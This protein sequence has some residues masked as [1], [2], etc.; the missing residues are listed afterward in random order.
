MGHADD[1]RFSVELCGGTHARRTGDIGLF[2]IV[3]DEALAAGV[4]R[5]E[6]VA[7][8]AAET[9]VAERDALLREAA[10]VLR[11]APEDLPARIGALVEERKKL[12]REL[13]DL[14]RKLA[15]GGP[16]AEPGGGAIKVGDITYVPR[17]LDGVPARDLKPMVDDIKKTI[18]SGV[19]ALIAND[20]GKASVV[21][22]VTE[23]L[24]ARVSAVDLVK[25]AVAALGG[26]GGGGRPDMAQGGGPNPDA[27]DAALK[28]I[29]EALAKERVN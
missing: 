29:E 20:D 1:E 19:V 11:A 26:K 18:K 13:G 14:R 5:I 15:T 28:A 21:V 22:G 7:A 9:R 4:R 3:R 17:K 10:T 12:E 16:A 6:A 27:A 25:P 8:A 23:D 24:L 2:K